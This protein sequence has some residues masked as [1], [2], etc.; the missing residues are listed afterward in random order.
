MLLEILLCILFVIVLVIIGMAL[1]L[2]LAHVGHPK[3]RISPPPTPPPHTPGPLPT[4]PLSA[5]R[6]H[7]TVPQRRKQHIPHTRVGRQQ[8]KGKDMKP[9]RGKTMRKR[10][11]SL[12]PVRRNSPIRHLV[13]PGAPASPSHPITVPL[14]AP[15]ELQH[16][17]AS[18]RHTD[19]VEDDS[20][21][22]SNAGDDRVDFSSGGSDE[23]DGESVERGEHSMTSEESRSPTE[24]KT[25]KSARG[26]KILDVCSYST[27][28]VFLMEGSSIILKDDSRTLVMKYVGDSLQRLFSFAGY[29][30]GVTTGE[31]GGKVVTLP[32]SMLSQRLW[33]W[34]LCPNYPSPVLHCSSSMDEQYLWLQGHEE[35]FL[36]HAG[37]DG[38]TLQY[39]KS[40]GLKKRCYGKDGTTYI[41]LDATREEAHVEEDTVGGVGVTE[42]RIGKTFV[43][44]KDATLG[45]DGRV[46]ILPKASRWSY[47]R[48]INWRPCY[49]A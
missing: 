3:G 26:M 30:H 41:V 43:G 29:L 44:V 31:C 7:E 10:S 18:L 27:Y 32:T 6:I 4:P 8:H 40:V 47:I 14:D 34:K 19:V 17:P 28:V 13:A 5:Y 23:S 49:V 9:K 22:V 1:I 2:L 38:V 11:T 48:M 39:R 20:P 33:Q 25:Y 21:Y 42:R 12:P 45:H 15:T 35:G 37:G 24:I 36:Y 46:Y 16:I